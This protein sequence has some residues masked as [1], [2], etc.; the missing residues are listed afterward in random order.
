[1]SEENEVLARPEPK[2]VPG[3]R[4]KPHAAGEVHIPDYVMH[5]FAF[6]G[7]VA[8]GNP[9][10]AGERSA[11]NSADFSLA[12][13]FLPFAGRLQSF[14]AYIKEVGRN[15]AGKCAAYR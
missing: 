3:K 2:G 9:A 12:P 10:A 13:I 7:R 11:P 8:S 4:N 1:M 6:P 15:C 5:D 14:W